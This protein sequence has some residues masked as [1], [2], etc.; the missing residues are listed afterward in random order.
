MFNITKI[1]EKWEVMEEIEVK[2]KKYQ[3]RVAKTAML[4][5]Q[6]AAEN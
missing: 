4:A 1:I 5:I 6:K 3:H 2:K